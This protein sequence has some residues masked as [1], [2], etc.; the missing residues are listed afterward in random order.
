MN[1]DSII[2]LSITSESV[3]MSQAGFGMPQILGKSAPWPELVRAYADPSEMLTDGFKK[4]DPLYRAALKLKSQS[5]CVKSFKIG[6]GDLNALYEADSNFYGLMLAEPTPEA[7][8]E[9]AEWAES[10]RILFGADIS[11]MDDLPK[12]LKQKGFNRTFAFY[13]PD[14]TEHAAA[15]FIGKLFPTQPGEA[16]WAFKSLATVSPCPLST[17][18]AAELDAHN[19]NRYVRI[20][21]VGVT[22]H[23]KCVSGEYIDTVRGIDWLYARIQERIF[24]LLRKNPKIPYTEKGVDLVR[25]EVM[26]QLKEAVVVGVLAAFPEPT[27]SA[28]RVV[29]ISELDKAKRILPNVSFTACLAG[30]IHALE[31]RGVVSL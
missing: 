3:Q 26:A 10:K 7:I 30:A 15:A 13:H 22:L 21:D 18:Q 29:D 27:V 28:P 1:L 9:T 23:G 19:M 2:N 11:K 6:H 24:M 5:P 25:C 17:Q 20:N 12:T 4:D 16:T 14:P 8:L 31:I